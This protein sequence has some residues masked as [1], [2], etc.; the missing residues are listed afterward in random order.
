MK[1]REPY[2][3]YSGE[4]KILVAETVIKERMSLKGA[5]RQFGIGSPAVIKRWLRIYKEEGKEA[6]LEERRGSFQRVPIQRPPRQ[7]AKDADRETLIK[8]VEWLRAENDYLKKLRALVL[9]EEA[10][11]KKQ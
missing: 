11:N 3:R 6:L 1:K 9:E 5:V 7:N 10:Q 8:E 2:K 4:L